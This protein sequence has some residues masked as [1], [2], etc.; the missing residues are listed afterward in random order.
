MPRMVVEGCLRGG[1][2]AQRAL[3]DLYAPLYDALEAKLAV[4]QGFSEEGLKRSI[5]NPLGAEGVFVGLDLSIKV[6]KECAEKCP[7]DTAEAK[8]NPSKA[9]LSTSPSSTRPSTGC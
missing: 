7:V 5:A 1:K 6:L 9:V 8:W 4:K 2:R 3:Y